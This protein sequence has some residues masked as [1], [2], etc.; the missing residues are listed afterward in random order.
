MYVVKVEALD[1][2]M[3]VECLG[4]SSAKRRPYIYTTINVSSN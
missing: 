4:K 2:V 1:V 3:I